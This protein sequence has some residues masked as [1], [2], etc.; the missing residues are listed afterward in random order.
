[1][2]SESTFFGWVDG[3]RGGGEDSNFPFEDNFLGSVL[4]CLSITVTATSSG[5]VTNNIPRE[6]PEELPP[7]L[8]HELK[9]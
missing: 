2:L 7:W 6:K 9:A 4:D 1:M 8:A 5:N 3:G